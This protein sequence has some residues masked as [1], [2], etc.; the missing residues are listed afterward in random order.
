MELSQRARLELKAEVFKALGH[1]LRMGIVEFLKDEE[2]CVSE[3]VK[4]VGTEVSNVSKHLSILKKARILDDRRDGMNVL[5]RLAMPCVIEVAACIEGVA[6]QKLE[7]QRS[8][9]VA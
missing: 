6:I 2:K 5:Y 1:P 4:H 3:I 7:E 8:L 9:L